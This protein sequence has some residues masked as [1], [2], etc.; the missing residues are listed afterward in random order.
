MSQSGLGWIPVI[1]TASNVCIT[2]SAAMKVTVTLLARSPAG[3]SSTE[4]PSLS[5]ISVA[6]LHN[7]VISVVLPAE[8]FV[9]VTVP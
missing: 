4:L 3:E 1:Y 5:V 2:S 7:G 8:A 6:Y 9:N